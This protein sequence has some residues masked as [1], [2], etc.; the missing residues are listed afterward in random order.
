MK[1]IKATILF[2]LVGL[3]SLQT[4]AQEKYDTVVYS[5]GMLAVKDSTGAIKALIV[6]RGRQIYTNAEGKE[7]TKEEQDQFLETNKNYKRNMLIGDNNVMTFCIEKTPEASEMIGKKIPPLNYKDVD[8]NEVQIIDGEN[9]FVLCFWDTSCGSCLVE[10]NVLNWIVDEFPDWKIIAITTEESSVIK[11][12]MAKQGFLWKN[13][14]IVTGYQNEYLQAI[15]SN[16]VHPT[17]VLVSKSGVIEKAYI[18][19]LLRRMIVDMDML[20]TQH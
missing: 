6:N 17:T 4:Y 11:E 20:T 9:R 14:Q 5:K 12:F 8:G 19:A 10:L 2:C 1:I 18:G 3:F 15:P 7:I 16:V 13:L